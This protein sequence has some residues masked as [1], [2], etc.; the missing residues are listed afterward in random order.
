VRGLEGVRTAKLKGGLLVGVLIGAIA[1]F[2]A[3]SRPGFLERAEFWTYDLRARAAAHP[4]EA[5]KD[6]VLIDVAE[7][8]IRD[9]ERNFDLSFPWPRALY[10]YITR[11]VAAG[12]PKAIIFDWFFQG[13]GALGVG[14]AAELAAALAEA[15]RSVIGVYLSDMPRAAEPPGGRWGGTV[16]SFPTRAEA[17]KAAIGIMAFGRHAYLVGDGPVTLLLGGEAGAADFAE[18]WTKLAGTDELKEIFPAPEPPPARTLSDAEV[19]GELTDERVVVETAGLSLAPPHGIHLADQPTIDAPLPTLA[20]AAR[21]GN[22]VQRPEDDGIMRRHVPLARHG[23][24]LFPSLPLAAYLATHPEITPRFDGNVLVL[25]DRRIPLDEKGRFGIR[26]HG[27]SRVYPH[28]SAYQVLQSYQQ[29][30]EGQRPVIAPSIFKDKYVIVSATANALADLRAS[31]VA[32]IHLG[33]A[34]NATALDNLLAGA[35]I[36]RYPALAEAGLAFGLAVGLAVLM[37]LFWSLLRSTA[38][39]L[40]ATGAGTALALA[41]YWMWVDHTFATG[42][43]WIAAA[44]PM[45]GAAVST[46]TALLV[47]SALERSDKRF[48]EKA[49][50]RY[51]SRT[52]TRQLMTHPE[53]LALGG[54]KREISV[55]FSDVAGF[56]TISEKL[57]PEELVALLNEYLTVMTDVID[58]HDGYVDKYIGD[59]VMAFW[60]GLIPDD[61]HAVKACRAAIAMRNECLRR[62]PDWERR[63]G[64]GLMARSGLNSGF[65]VV[66]NMGSQNKYNYTAM[67]D[68]VNVASRLE[69]ANKAYATLL[70]ISETTYEYVK[71]L[72]DV[73]ELDFMTV[74][75]K[76]KPI[77]VYEVLEEKGKADPTLLAAVSRYHAGL[78]HYKARE[79]RD[80]QHDFAAAIAIKPDDGPSSVYLTRCE[81]FLAEPPAEDWDGVWHMKEK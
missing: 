62:A 15:G 5:A 6:I 45:G 17:V 21:L 18:S 19:A 44:V 36:Q 37:A 41:G 64:V 43:V 78:R 14:D 81:H 57:P 50:N 7:Q 73:R 34:I 54:A 76:N 56:T 26:F 70:M 46:F 67:G 8:D 39:A 80:A 49:L 75:G 20:V 68:M 74:K 77:V 71:D 58:A 24:L 25:G 32:R 4:D 29:V 33:A 35:S 1:G 55:Y 22:V 38:A 28:V 66:G 79:F 27:G 10:G 65:G 60:G 12:A 30:Q 59:A 2:A 72:V 16:R 13:R 69:G 42:G 53:Y 3:W 31:P 47:A 52:L 61:Q 23:D 40:A 9:V 63:F 48:I 11:H 51:T